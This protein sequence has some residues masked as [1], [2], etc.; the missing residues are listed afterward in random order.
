MLTLRQA[1]SMLDPAVDDHWTAQGLPRM[2][3]IADFM[4]DVTVKRSEVTD[5]AP[6]LTRE[7]AASH[8]WSEDPP[9]MTGGEQPKQPELPVPEQAPPEPP[10]EAEPEA[11]QEP[12]PVLDP[13]GSVLDM[14]P[15][16][17]FNDHGLC[18]RA[19]AEMAERMGAKQRDLEAVKAELDKLSNWNETL[20]RALALHSRRGGKP[21]P[22]PVQA[23]LKSQQAARAERAARARRF[24]E[25]GTTAQDVA[26][27]LQGA[28]KI[29]AAMRQRKPGLG[30]KRPAPRPL[31]GA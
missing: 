13:T 19:L 22:S 20:K 7:T 18:E 9:L 30:A 2:D 14:D 31:V 1:L 12:A 25:A 28:S 17:V 24:I 6:A 21:E 27:E 10:K 23:F 26:A 16:T 11:P 29:D 5:A 8:T 3:A 4:Q 15:A